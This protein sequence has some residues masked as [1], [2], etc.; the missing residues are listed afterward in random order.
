[1]VIMEPIL[2]TSMAMKRSK[3]PTKVHGSITI[4]TESESRSTPVLVH[5]RVTGPTEN[6]AEK[7]S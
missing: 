3:T 2:T 7:A 6:D 5:I 1:M 4:R